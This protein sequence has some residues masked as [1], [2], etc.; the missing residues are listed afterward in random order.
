MSNIKLHRT[1]HAGL[2]YINLGSCWRFVDIHEKWDPT[3]IR[4][5]GPQYKTKNE[6]LADYARYAA[7]W[8]YED[9]STELEEYLVLVEQDDDG[10]KS[11][12]H[13]PCEA[14]TKS[15]AEEQ[16]LGHSEGLIIIAVYKRV[17]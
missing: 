8:G 3:H 12:W 15:H 9:T 11:R 14:E 5:I 13:F 10:E 4:A 1:R 16:A 17:K 6:L 7:T 2:G